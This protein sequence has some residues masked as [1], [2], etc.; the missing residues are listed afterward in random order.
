[1]TELMRNKTLFVRDKVMI[2]VLNHFSWWV[3][4]LLLHAMS[5]KVFYTSIVAIMHVC[6]L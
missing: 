3:I 4:L 5:S 2:L 6:D 1:M